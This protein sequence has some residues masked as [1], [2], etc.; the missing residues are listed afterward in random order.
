MVVAGFYSCQLKTGVI[1]QNPDNW[2]Y[3][4]DGSGKAIFLTGSHTWMR[5]LSVPGWPDMGWDLNKWRK[6]IQFL[7]YWNHN[8]IRMWMW[9]HDGGTA[10]CIWTKM[11][12]KFDLNSLNQ[13]YFDR[14]KSFVEEAKNNNIYVGVMLFQGWSGAQSDP[15]SL[16]DLTHE[17]LENLTLQQNLFSTPSIE[18]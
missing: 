7:K 14:V 15:R 17:I 11:G 10:P 6:H 8:F 2:R 1:K 18:L 5:N 4:D 16:S 12:G 13:A 3:F 9:E